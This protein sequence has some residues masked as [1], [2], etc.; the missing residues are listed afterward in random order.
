MR[1][2]TARALR[3]AVTRGF[4]VNVPPLGGRATGDRVE[5]VVVVGSDACDRRIVRDLALL[6][7]LLR[8]QRVQ[9]PQVVDHGHQL[10]EDGFVLGMLGQQDAVQNHLE[11]VLYSLQQLGVS[12]SGAICSWKFLIS[13]FSQKKRC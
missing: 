5:A 9:R 10:G 12:K 13:T 8:V 3:T 1:V 2:A 11:L 4:P 7:E 6:Q